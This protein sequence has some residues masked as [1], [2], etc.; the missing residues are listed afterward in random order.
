METYLESRITAKSRPRV[1]Q[2]VEATSAGVGRHVT[3]LTGAL[4]DR[5]VEVHLVYSPLRTDVIFESAVDRYRSHPLCTVWEVGMRR[6]PWPGDIRVIALLRR[7]I[8]ANGPFDVVHFHS[9]KAGM[10]GRVAALGLNTKRIYTPHALYTLAPEISTL[11][12]TVAGL[13]ER[14]LAP[15]ADHI[16][17]VSQAEHEHARSL[18][19][20]AHR[21]QTIP[22][23][24]PLDWASA[25]R[26][27]TIRQ[28][29]GIAA[30]EAVIG[31]IGRLTTQK[32][33]EL[34]LESFR[35]MPGDI[36]NAATLALVGEGPLR[37]FLE[38]LAGRLGIADRIRW[39]GY[40]D[41]RTIVPAFDIFALPSRYEGFPY[42]VLEAMA[43]GLPVVTTAV[44]GIAETISPGENG[45]V[46]P[47][48]ARRFSE[49]LAELAVNE[50]LRLNMGKESRRKAP[51]FCLDKMVD[52]LLELYSQFD[53][54]RA[55]VP[56][57]EVVH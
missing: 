17:L 9:T 34:L 1:L 13:T 12:R 25:A 36:R 30:N 16:V 47:H 45:Y 21:L 2:L 22:L 5:D 32:S 49:A 19:L 43:C 48:D 15:L 35:M 24:I 23:G 53:T 3:E 41:G 52:R 40:R 14:V 26:R 46:V 38:K 31:F 6:M 27:S 42:T 39:L 33:P 50:Q 51:A 20:P 8:R 10:V 57:T 44:G 54:S 11:R 29:L 55:Q 56:E 37:P 28:Q 7:H 18:G 4:L